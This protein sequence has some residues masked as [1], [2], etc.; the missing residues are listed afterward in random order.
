LFPRGF[1]WGGKKIERPS[2][3]VVGSPWD[4]KNKKISKN[5]GKNVKFGEYLGRGFAL[6]PKRGG[7][8]C[9]KARFLGTGEKKALAGGVL[10][11]K[12]NFKNLKKRLLWNW[13]GEGGGAFPWENI[14]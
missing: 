12:K 4:Q 7:A 8:G 13:A 10:L 2:E 9:P 11:L 5:L 6:H 14:L 1:P 3:L